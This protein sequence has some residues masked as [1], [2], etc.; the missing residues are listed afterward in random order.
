MDLDVPAGT[1]LALLGPSGC[2]KSTLLKA[3]AGLL[4]P[5]HGDI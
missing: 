4:R 1:V 2:G 3:L 5:Q